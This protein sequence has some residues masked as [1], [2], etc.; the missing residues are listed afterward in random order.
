M[1]SPFISKYEQI[2]QELS[3]RIRNGSYP[4]ESKLPSER[5]LCTEF[6]VSVITVR[7]ALELLVKTGEIIK[8]NG[9]GSYVRKKHI[10]SSNDIFPLEPQPAKYR[11]SLG[12][13]NPSPVEELLYKT[14]A[15]LFHTENPEMA[16]DIVN[17]SH[18]RSPYSDGWLELISRNQLPSCGLFYYYGMYVQQDALLPLENMEGFQELCSQLDPRAIREIENPR[19]DRSVYAIASSMTTSC[20][21]INTEIFSEVGIDHSGGL[22]DW[23]TLYEWVSAIHAHSRKNHKHKLIPFALGIPNGTR[24]IIG[25]LPFLWQGI[26]EEDFDHSSINCF[27]SI[28]DSKECLRGL[29]YLKKLISFTPAEER[30]ITHSRFNIGDAGIL[31]QGITVPLILKETMYEEISLKAFVIPPE[32][33]KK[34]FHNYYGDGSFGIFKNGIRSE[35]EKQVAWEWLRFLF[36]RKQQYMISSNMTCSTLKGCDLFIDKK[37]SQCAKVVRE[38]LAHSRKQFDF[39]GVR[40]CLSVVSDE[41]RQFFLSD[42]ISAQKCIRSIQKKLQDLKF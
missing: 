41:L 4:P 37:H 17:I 28:F 15:G 7:H 31:L 21:M 30:D 27:K 10:F 2:H 26:K 23:E 40:K 33:K 35:K 12:L 39:P 1:R 24:Q 29:K 20:I 25:I 13:L 38:T 3:N 8:K 5:E 16:V 18:P 11:I 14:F 19:G 42:N 36:R 9:S 32:N 6:Q 34:I 22:P